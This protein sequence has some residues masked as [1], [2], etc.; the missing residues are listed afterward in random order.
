MPQLRL[1]TIFQAIIISK[2][3][4]AIPAWHG[5]LTGEQVG[6]IN[7]FEHFSNDFINTVFV[8]IVYG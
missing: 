6:Q 5:V 4:Y 8:L 1:N 7:A 3:A 2:I